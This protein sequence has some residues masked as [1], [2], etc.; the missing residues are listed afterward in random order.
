MNHLMAI[1]ELEGTLKFPHTKM[2]F[3]QWPSDEQERFIS[4]MLTSEPSL[5]FPPLGNTTDKAMMQTVAAARA[6]RNEVSNEVGN[7][8]GNEVSNENGPGNGILIKEVIFD[9]LCKNGYRF[10]DKDWDSV[11]SIYVKS[12]AEWD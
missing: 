12:S 1:N 2:V 7:E 8:V 5:A 4:G 6:R 3:A 9:F 11:T 10:E